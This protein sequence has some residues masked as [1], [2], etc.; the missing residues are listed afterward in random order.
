MPAALTAF[1][2]ALEAGSPLPDDVTLAWAALD[3]A[4]LGGGYRSAVCAAGGPLAV[5]RQGAI[6]AFS[7]PRRRR[8]VLE[9]QA[10]AQRLSLLGPWLDGG[11]LIVADDAALVRLADHPV[12]ALYARA[13]LPSPA[14][15]H[16]AIVGSREAGPRTLMRVRRLA[17]RLVAEGAVVVSGGAAGVDSAAHDGAR[18]AGGA[19]VVISGR[20]IGPRV[21]PAPERGVSWVTPYPPWSP[22][23]PTGRFA[24]RNAYIAAMADVTVAVCG[25]PRSGTRHTVLAANIFGR[26]VATLAPD[27]DEPALAPLSTMIVGADA[28]ELI[29]DDASLATLLA[30]R[31]R[32]GAH[33][34]FLAA[35]EAGVGAPVQRALPLAVP[36]GHD[37]APPAAHPVVRLLEQRGALSIDDAAV[38]LQQSVRELMADVAMLEL[39]G[40]VRRDGALLALACVVG[41][42]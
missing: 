42:S 22:G 1:V 25:G 38:A 7:S 41:D 8:R 37:V 6:A 21:E 24:Q 13:P 17:A 27:P 18:D 14:A 10:I 29:D 4:G 35:L 19:V 28:G 26:P 34:R 12:F 20:A 16:V 31:V 39:D 11:G 9:P 32:P 5:L 40:A 33:A 23:V 3:A 2:A 30:I 15:P 36:G